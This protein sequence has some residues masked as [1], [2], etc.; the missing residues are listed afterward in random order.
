LN[1]WLILWV[2][3]AVSLI[4]FMV[5]TFSILM[6]Q[7]RAWSIYA[8]KRKL[9]YK[10]NGLSESP[11][12]S[13]VMGDHTVALFPS[14]HLSEDARGVRKL[15]AIEINL[16]CV[17]P[18]DGGIAT[19]GMIPI[20]K[21]LQFKHE[22]SPKHKSWNKSY[23]ASS[24]NKNVL[25]AYMSDERVSAMCDLIEI[26]HS[27]FILVF[28]GDAMLLRIDLA[29]PLH[30]PK[31]LDQ[32][33]KKMLKVAAV[34]ELKKGEG[35]ILKSEA[36]KSAAKGVSLEVDEDGLDAPV[37]LVLEEDAVDGALDD[38]VEPEPLASDAAP[39]KKKQKDKKSS[40]SSKKPAKKK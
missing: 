26:E 12:L 21:T 10:S 14:E 39:A 37:G 27:W 30:N 24:D 29:D 23:V 35:K 31:R 8:E 16:N 6:R 34:L 4:A 11:E 25:K 18:V 19:K 7:K 13:G 20:L 28:K 3:L 9:R 22:Y 33:L 5:W 2:L 15:T 38:V 32:V 1:V 40:A 17:M 36:L